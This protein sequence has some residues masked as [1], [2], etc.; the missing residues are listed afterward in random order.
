MGSH[1]GRVGT[2]KKAKPHV[3]QRNLYEA[4]RN[5]AADRVREAEAIEW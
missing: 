1:A 4:Y 2:R 5:M 3:A